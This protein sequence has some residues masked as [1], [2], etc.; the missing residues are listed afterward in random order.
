[1]GNLMCIRILF[2]ELM[3]PSDIIPNPD[4]RTDLDLRARLLEDL[5]PKRIVKR[6]A[7]FLSPA[8]KQVTNDT[9]AE[10]AAL[11]QEVPVPKEDRFR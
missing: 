3:V 1:M 5:A 11:R 9:V 8:G 6:L 10:I 2:G 4:K 7:E